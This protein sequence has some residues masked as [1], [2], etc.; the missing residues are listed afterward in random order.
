MSVMVMV[1][2]RTEIREDYKTKPGLS[3]ASLSLLCLCLNWEKLA[4]S[5]YLDVRRCRSDSRLLC[6]ERFARI[7]SFIPRLP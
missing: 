4:Y 1:A 3:M 2:A 5:H 6:H 7:H